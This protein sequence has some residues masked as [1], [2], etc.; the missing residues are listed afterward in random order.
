[1]RFLKDVFNLNSQ[2]WEIT[3]K[4]C[5]KIGLVLGL[6]IGLVILIKIL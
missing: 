2:T 5:L 4:Y 1:M 6:F 3:A